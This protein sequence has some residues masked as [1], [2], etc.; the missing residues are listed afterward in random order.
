M[1]TGVL[2]GIGSDV[3]SAVDQTRLWSRHMAL[4]AFGRRADGGVNRQALSREDIAARKQLVSWAYDSGY[5]VFTDVVGNLF[6]R[7]EGRRSE[8]P[9]IM[10]GS[11]LDS[12]P[13]GGKFDG[14]FGVLAGMEVLQALDA[15]NIVT[16]M[17]VEVV[18]WTNEEGSRFSPGMTGSLAFAGQLDPDDMMSIA[19]ETGISFGE[20]LADVDKAFADLPRRQ[21]GFPV[22]CYIEAHIEQGP[23]LEKAN[24]NIGVVS[25]IQ[26]TRWFTVTV[27]GKAMHAG[28]V[29]HKMRKDAFRAA[30]SMINAL[31][32]VMTDN[33]DVIRFTIGR[34]LVQPNSPNTIPGAVTF[35][36]DFRHPDL[37][38]LSLLG[39]QVI[40][41][42]R[43]NAKGCEI[44]IQETLT[45]YPI[46]F[47]SWLVTKIAD[48]AQALGLTNIVLPSGAFHDAKSMSALCPTGM[49]FVPCAEGISHS[50]D[51]K[52]EPDAL[53][54]GARVL[55]ATIAEI[56]KS[57]EL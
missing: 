1:N 11:H 27:T 19:D 3:A 50:P 28:T 9:P 49:I 2:T 52:A 42:C 4:A 20:A 38:V 24:C 16:D 56:A 47:P 26:G 45:S 44:D 25:G 33:E 34:V 14:V 46:T 18:V 39:D 32:E 43:E 8:L 10:T 55:A 31:S 23:V 15:C 53:A 36:V 51:E 6:I 17:P 30:L 37:S 29:P 57:A 54:A 22:S 7:R 48:T 12:Q 41:I 13:A 5:N 21:L 40:R 35:T